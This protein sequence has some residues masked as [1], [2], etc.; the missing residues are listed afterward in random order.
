MLS[1]IHITSLSSSHTRLSDYTSVVAQ[2]EQTAKAFH[3]LLISNLLTCRG[4]AAPHQASFLTVVGN[5]AGNHLHTNNFHFYA[6]YMYFP[7][8]KNLAMIPTEF[9]LPLS[10]C[11]DTSTMS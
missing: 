5:I 7:K 8:K 11:S 6:A 4:F 2:C 10:N 1:T 3:Y 9:Q